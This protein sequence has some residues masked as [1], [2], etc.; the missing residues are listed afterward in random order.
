MKQNKLN[1]LLAAL[2]VFTLT[3]CSGEEAQ[4]TARPDPVHFESGDEC[5]VCGM[6]IEGFPGPKGQ[7][8]NEKDQ[9]VRKFCSTRDMFAWL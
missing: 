9:Q 4:T 1:W 8:F 3:A 2:A 5:H 7:A 6:I